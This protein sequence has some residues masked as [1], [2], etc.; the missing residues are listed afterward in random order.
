MSSSQKNN[1][2]LQGHL[3][4]GSNVLITKQG[5]RCKKCYFLLKN[6]S[7]RKPTNLPA[8]KSEKVEDSQ[9]KQFF[10]PNGDF[11]YFY[12]LGY[13]NRKIGKKPSSQ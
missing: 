10:T 12:N 4:L 5:T 7:Q 13:G 2:Y 3:V 8:A 11:T 1:L 6:K 9:T